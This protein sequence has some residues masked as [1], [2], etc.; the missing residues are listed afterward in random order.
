MQRPP[1]HANGGVCG[2]CK[3]H[4]PGT[5]QSARRQ[6]KKHISLI[7]RQWRSRAAATLQPVPGFTA[8]PPRS[9]QLAPRNPAMRVGFAGGFSFAGSLKKRPPGRAGWEK[10]PPKVQNDAAGRQVS[11]L[12]LVE[13]KVRR[14]QSSRGSGGR[15]QRLAKRARKPHPPAGQ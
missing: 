14:R 13:W 11:N 9:M 1:P 15:G 3:G 7:S 6:K 12:P 4:P 8:L 10:A 2:E 5:A